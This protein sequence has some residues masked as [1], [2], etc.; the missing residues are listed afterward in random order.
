MAAR[1]HLSYGN[2]QKQQIRRN[3]QGQCFKQEQDPCPS[4]IDRPETSVKAEKN[5]S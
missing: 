1:E 4:K 5:A 2:Q 3:T